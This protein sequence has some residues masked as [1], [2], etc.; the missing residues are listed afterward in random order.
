MF[1]YQGANMIDLHNN[2]CL[3]LAYAPS[4]RLST[5]TLVDA[6]QHNVI[7]EADSMEWECDLKTLWLTR[8]RWSMMVRQYLD[9][10]ETTAW[11]NQCSEKIGTRGRGTAVLR[12]RTVKPRGGAATGHTNKESRRWGSCMLN[13]SYKAL[14]EPT[15]TLHSRTSYLGYLSVLDLTIA[16]MLG[17]YV[18]DAISHTSS[19]SIKVEDF[20]FVWLV[21]SIQWHAFKSLAWLL[22][23][24]D[25]ANRR[26]GRAVLLKK[27]DSLDPDLL[28]LIEV[29]AIKA[30]RLWLTKVRREDQAGVTYG[31]MTYNTYRRIRRRWHTEV[32]GYDKAVTFEGENHRG[33]YFKAYRPLPHCLTSSLNLDPIR[34]PRAH[35]PNSPY[36][37]EDEAITT[38]DY[39][40]CLECGDLD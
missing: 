14:P 30:S 7:A 5:H 27:K 13:V 8:S 22:C 33:E 37:P 34:V 19:R 40:L 28:K 12:T 24:E 10:A 3:G 35:G 4:E 31:D 39:Y 32:L 2:M 11:I 23:N 16:W 18:A 36:L 9:P 21:E 17:K 1:T 25:E 15:I 29:P 38:E 6:S 20:R 26:V